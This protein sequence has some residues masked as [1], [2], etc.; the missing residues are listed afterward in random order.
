MEWQ[1]IETAPKDGK[2]F[3]MGWP[4]YVTEM[5][6]WDCGTNQFVRDVWQRGEIEGAEHKPDP[7][8]AINAKW[9]PLPNP[10]KGE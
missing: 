3:L 4:D 10:P 1:P 6:M 8:D 2:S 9:M 7:L 5:A